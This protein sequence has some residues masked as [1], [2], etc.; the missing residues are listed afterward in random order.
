[1]QKCNYNWWPHPLLFIQYI[2]WGRSGF[3]PTMKVMLTAC[4]LVVCQLLSIDLFGTLLC[5]NAQKW[6][7]T[8]LKL[9]FT[10]VFRVKPYYFNTL[11]H[12]WTSTVGNWSPHHTVTNILRAKP[13]IRR[14]T[15]SLEPPRYIISEWSLFGCHNGAIFLLF[16]RTQ[17]SLEG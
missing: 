2:R 11:C 16:L 12:I 10:R 17:W 9:A 13:V 15:V 8:G 1:M 6:H 3:T 14:D 7:E 4:W 5:N